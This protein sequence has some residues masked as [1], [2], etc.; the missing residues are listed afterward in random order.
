MRKKI[1]DD[2]SLAC[3][4]GILLFSQRMENLNQRVID[5][6]KN[7]INSNFIG[8]L[9][10]IILNVSWFEFILCKIIYRKWQWV[11]SNKTKNWLIIWKFWV[12]LLKMGIKPI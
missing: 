10:K 8:T 9:I 7:L 12:N 1:Y 5:I 3:F 2:R 11:W 6:F 4:P